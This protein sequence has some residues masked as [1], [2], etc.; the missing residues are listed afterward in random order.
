MRQSHLTGVENYDQRMPLIHS[1]SITVSIPKTGR[2]SAR[3]GRGNLNWDEILPAAEN[4]GCAWFIVEQDT[5]EGDAF[6]A[7]QIS[8]DFLHARCH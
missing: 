5:C 8:F 7:L 1:E 3:S 2:F 4:A 6:E